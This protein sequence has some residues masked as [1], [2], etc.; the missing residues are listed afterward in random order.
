[1][2]RS[3]LIDVSPFSQRQTSPVAERMTCVLPI[4]L[5]LL[6]V[7]VLSPV[8]STNRELDDDWISAESVYIFKFCCMAG[9]ALAIA[10]LFA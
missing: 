3:E 5:W 2:Q 4:G 10:S 9:E 8:L 6:M 7:S 1:M